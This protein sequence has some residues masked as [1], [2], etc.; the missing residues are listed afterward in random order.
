LGTE[1]AGVNNAK[2]VVMRIFDAAST[3]ANQVY[4]KGLI[5]AGRCVCTQTDFP[6]GLPTEGALNFIRYKYI[7]Q[8]NKPIR[9]IALFYPTTAIRLDQNL[10]K[11]FYLDAISL[12]QR[13]DFEFID[14]QMISDGA[15][16][17]LTTLILFPLFI[18]PEEVL[19]YILA[20]ATSGRMAFFQKQH[21]TLTV[22]NSDNSITHISVPALQNGISFYDSFPE[23]LSYIDAPN[24]TDS[25]RSFQK[26]PSYS[27]YFEKL[28]LNYTE[29]PLHLLSSPHRR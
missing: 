19:S 22:V 15:L 24:I 29:S 3:N 25:F 13:L 16:S 8:G 17:S 27:T 28:T 20:W 14:E 12:R 21:K 2:G 18:I 5:G 11:A 1:E 26:P 6:V 23:L 7:L 4:F 9:N 10:L